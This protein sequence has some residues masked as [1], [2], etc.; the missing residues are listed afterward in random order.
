MGSASCMLV[1]RTHGPEHGKDVNSQAM[2]LGDGDGGGVSCPQ[3][4]QDSE[5]MKSKSHKSSS[6]GSASK[7]CCPMT[8]MESGIKKG[9][10][11]VG[12]VKNPTFLFKVPSK[13]VVF[14]LFQKFKT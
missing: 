11:K 7:P 3:Q 6:T 13:L 10:K 9:L 12:C 14:F 1:R 4:P 5:D 2:L 8:D